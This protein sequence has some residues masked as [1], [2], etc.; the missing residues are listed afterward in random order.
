MA[1]CPRQV[2]VAWPHRAEADD[3]ALQVVGAAGAPHPVV[4]AAGVLLLAAGVAGVLPPVAV[5][6]YGAHLEAV[7]VGAGPAAEVGDD[8]AHPAVVEACCT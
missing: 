4:G 5:V 8:G 1:A 6:A 2:E 3:V 7:V